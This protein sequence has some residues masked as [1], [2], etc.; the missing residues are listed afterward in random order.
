M[1]VA[2]RVS[3]KMKNVSI[4]VCSLQCMCRSKKHVFMC[5]ATTVLFRT[6]CVFISV[7]VTYN[8]YF[9]MKNVS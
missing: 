9:R 2:Y 5:V 3:F 4:Y 8:V 7:C 1:R 6:K